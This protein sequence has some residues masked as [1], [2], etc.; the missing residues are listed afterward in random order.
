MLATVLGSV[1]TVKI[2]STFSQ[3]AYCLVEEKI[4]L[5]NDKCYDGSMQSH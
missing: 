3:E 4:I 1:D 2:K 5:K